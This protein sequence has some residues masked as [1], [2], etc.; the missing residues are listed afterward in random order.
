M[1]KDFFVI[2]NCQSGSVMPL[3]EGIAGRLAMYETE[4]DAKIAGNENILGKYFGFE[5]FELGM[6]V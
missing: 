1:T 2:L 4:E 5:V 6:G 3:V